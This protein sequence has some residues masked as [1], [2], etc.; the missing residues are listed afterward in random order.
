MQPGSTARDDILPLPYATDCGGSA[1]VTAALTAG[2]GAEAEGPAHASGALGGGIDAWSGAGCACW[3]ASVNDDAGSGMETVVGWA[4]TPLSADGGGAGSVGTLPGEETG[5]MAQP[6][7]PLPIAA[8]GFSSRMPTR[9]GACPPPPGHVA[10]SKNP[11]R[12]ARRPRESDVVACVPLGAPEVEA[13]VRA[14]VSAEV[15]TVVAVDVPATEGPL[16]GMGAGAAVQAAWL[17]S[18]VER[19]RK[20]EN[21]AKLLLPLL[22]LPAEAASAA[23][24]VT[25][26]PWPAP[27]PRLASAVLPPELQPPQ[28]AAQLQ[29]PRLEEGGRAGGSIVAALRT[30]GYKMS[31][32]IA[33]V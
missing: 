7:P 17:A 28:L 26:R 25:G 11:A 33:V 22:V 1:A 5:G 19:R 29:P 3:R 2:A 13:R 27:S 23:A 31:V 12:R 6:P 30:G 18:G 4:H 15:G 32:G 10:R 20:R 9:M 24:D 14:A 16:P 21:E 8:A